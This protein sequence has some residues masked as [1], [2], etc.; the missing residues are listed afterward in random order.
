MPKIN[1]KITFSLPSGMIEEIQRLEKEERKKRSELLKEALK[2]YIEDKEWKRIFK[3][4]ESRAKRLG[5]KKED[6]EKLVDEVREE[7]KK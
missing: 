5:I 2:R 6:V 3:Y 4:G 1:N 7:R